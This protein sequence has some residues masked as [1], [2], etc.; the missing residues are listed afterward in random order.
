[1]KKLSIRFAISGRLYSL[2]GLLAIGC[3]AL[4][5]LLVWMQG[6]RLMNARRA[7]LESLVEVALGVLDAHHK[8]AQSGAISEEEA[9]KRAYAAISGMRYGQGNSDFYFIQA[10]DGTTLVNPA[11]PKAIGTS[12][13]DTK[14]TKGKFFARELHEEVNKR[15]H[16][17]ATYYIA[18]ANSTEE[19]EKTTFIKL[20]APWNVVVATGVYIDD[21]QAE[22]HAAMWQA[23]LATFVLVL[24]LGGVAFLIARSIAR[25]MARLRNVMRD[26]AEGRQVDAVVDITRNDE[27]GDM[28]KAVE[29]FRDN[30]AARA[31][32]EE[33]AKADAADKEMREEKA[34]LD[35]ADRIAAQEKARLEQ[36]A[37]QEKTE[38]LIAEFRSSIG[39]VLSAVGTNMQKLENT[40]SSL[41]AVAGQAATQATEAAAASE[42]SAGNVQTVASAAEELGGSVNE[43]GRQVAQANAVVAEA[44]ELASRSNGQIETL[45]AAAQ[46]IG[47]VVELISSI[48]AQTNLLALN[49]TIEAARAGE[50]GKG[51]AVVAQEVKTLASQTAK[52]TEE[53]GHQVAGIQASTKDAVEAI[54]KIATTMTEISRFTTSL[55]AT[56]EEQTAATAEISRNV[57]EAAKG[58]NAVASNISTV[59]MA[60]GEANRSADQVLGASGELAQAAD[61]LKTAVDGFL[62]EVAA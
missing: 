11:N 61:R 12:R 60:I 56:V 37:R 41:A 38:Q 9:K 4:T 19:V 49:A 29:V 51:F 6:E 39:S 35:A 45:A 48:A 36:A 10:R 20:Y 54:G 55:S 53:I 62:T 28:A 25:P 8:Q 40:A 24:L 52:A 5:A 7:Q 21:I 34:R 22:T 30:A 23:A 14:D 16:G 43:I 33:K 32:L 2:V 18:K 31:A 26:L 59:T 47:D 1:M 3:A 42:Q 50:A 46:K 58:T 17:F 15:G 44:T 57:A 13:L 27:I